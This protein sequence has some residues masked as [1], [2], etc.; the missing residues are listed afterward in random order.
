VEGLRGLKRIQ[1][2]HSMRYLFSPEIDLIFQATGLRRIALL[3]WL[4]TDTPSIGSWNACFVAE[5]I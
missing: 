5:K 3:Q 1:E 2:V 4:N